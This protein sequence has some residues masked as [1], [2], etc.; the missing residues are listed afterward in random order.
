MTFQFLCP[1]GHLLQ[2]EE[3]QTGQQSICPI[4]HSV[5]LIPPAL[6]A[7]A[8]SGPMPPASGQVPPLGAG[9]PSAEWGASVAPGPGP[10]GPTLAP[11]GEASWLA[12]GGS[13]PEGMGAGAGWA[14]PSSPEPGAEFP[15]WAPSGPQQASAEGGP[16]PPEVSGEEALESSVV[17]ILCPSG[18]E[19]ETPREMLG[20]EAL[21]PFCQVQFRLRWEDSREYRREKQLELQRRMARQSKLWLQW[22]IA[23]AVVVVTALIIMIVVAASH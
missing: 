14:G 23:A 8:S 2:A 12:T 22:S 1:Q 9:N 13:F 20:Q 19:L 17:H 6:S 10:G 3:W 11:M 7:G 16:S 18:H 21:C 4:C 15:S 5:F